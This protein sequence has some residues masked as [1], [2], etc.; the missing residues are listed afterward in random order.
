MIKKIII[1]ALVGILLLGIPAAIYF[2]K[3]QQVSKVPITPLPTATLIPPTPTRPPATPTPTEVPITTNLPTCS[4][5]TLN[6]PA[7]GTAP[8]TVRFTAK[9]TDSDGII[10]KVTFRFGDGQVVE[11]TRGG[12]IGTNSISI[13]ASHT[14]TT[15]GTYTA[16]AVLND[17]QGGVS[18]EGECAQAITVAGGT[19]AAVNPTATP[20]GTLT[21]TPTPTRTPTPTKSGQ[22]PTSTLNQS[23]TPT[24]SVPAPTIESPGSD[25][26]FS[27]GGL[28]AILLIVGAF[29]FFTL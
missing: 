27:I 13:Q 11:N 10:K 4:D 2:F 6:R 28:A 17:D 19:G 21:Q 22:T 14:Y 25:I 15:A 8:F 29:L 16:E 23:P 9:G 12:G 5:L 3:Q 7:T 1:G 20:S 24:H 18:T 26:M